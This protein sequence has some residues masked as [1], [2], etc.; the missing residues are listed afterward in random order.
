MAA[1]QTARGLLLHRAR[2]ARGRVAAYRIVAPT[3]WNFHPEG[4]L[5]RGL[6]GMIADDEPALERGA[7]LVVQALDPCV[8]CTIEVTHAWCR[9][10]TGASRSGRRGSRSKGSEV[11]DMNCHA[12][13]TKKMGPSF[14][15][16]A[17]KL[18]GKS[19]AEVVAALKAAKPH[20]SVKASD[21]DLK[22][23]GKWIQ[24]L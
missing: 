10:T 7:T 12:V 9:P 1:V 22:A 4:P 14:K 24:S 18:K 16:A 17:A 15:D 8:A 20:A 5:A 3:E 6:A 2:I 19:D 21:D 13:D 11:T 23:I